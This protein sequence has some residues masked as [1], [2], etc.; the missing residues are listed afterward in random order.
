[1]QMDFPATDNEARRL[2]RLD[3]Y[4][5]LDSVPEPAY[6]DLLAIATSL[7][8]TPMGA[9]TL[10]DEQRQWFK[11]RRGVALRET[12]RDQAFCAHAI[13]H[14]E[15]LM[16]VPDTLQDSRFRDHPLVTGTPGI[17]F[18]AGEKLIS[19]DGLAMGTLCVLDRRPRQLSRFQ[20]EAMAALARQATVLMELRRANKRLHEVLVQRDQYEEQLRGYQSHLETQN[21]ELMTQSR[22]DP[23]TGLPNRRALNAALDEGVVLAREQRQSMSVAVIDID[24][25]KHINDT[26]GHAIGDRVLVDVARLIRNEMAPHHTASRFG[27]EE[28]VVV[29]PG[30]PLDQAVAMCERIRAAMLALPVDAP[31]SV[32]IGVTAYRQGDTAEST[33]TR[34][35]QALYVAKHNGR[36][37]VTAR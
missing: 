25:F 33:F 26:L 3:S 35:D 22:L 7:C 28:F 13:N 21:A 29:M 31:A 1:M 30:L 12:S 5:I 15:S 20:R 17:R 36:N 2:Q 9:V 23:L 24:Y 8:A 32:S 14:E 27:G 37:R 18:Y 10:V 19:P 4:G 16:V 34:A 11:A 6:D